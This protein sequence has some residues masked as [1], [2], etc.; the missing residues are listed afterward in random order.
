VGDDL[1]KSRSIADV[2]NMVRRDRNHPSV[3]IWEAS[4]NESGMD[5]VYMQAAHNAVHE[6]YP[7]PYTYTSGWIDAVYDIYIPARQHAKPPYYWNKYHMKKPILIS[8]YGDWEYYAQ[9]AGF[10]QKAYNDIT[11]EERNSRQL[12]SYG[13]KRLMQQALNFQ[14]AHNDNL[15]GKNL[16][17]ANWLMFD[18]NRGY[19]P[20]IESSGIADIFRLPKFAYY[21]YQSQADILAN[22]MGGFN[23][24]MVVIA[25]YYNDPSSQEIKVYSNCDEVELLLN[26]K[27]VGKQSADKAENSKNLTHAPFT[28]TLK[29]F[30][31]GTL[32][33]NAY[34]AG[35][36]MASSAQTTPS[37]AV[38]LKLVLDESGKPLTKACGD[39]VFVYASVVDKDGV[40]VPQ[41]T[42]R[43]AFTV[44][45]DATL[46]GANPF[47]A[48]AG[49]ATI[50]LK[51]GDSAGN[52]TIEASSPGLQT[53]SLRLTL[54]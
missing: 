43:V 22:Q 50:L 52:I 44:K 4:L 34:V 1:F 33:A 47:E 25:N 13:Q 54:K 35:K 26:G 31:P 18:Y 49:I 9:N 7:A 14:E 11:E 6:E 51:A 15:N 48:E 42:N 41:A 32:T 21:F 12:R 53:T 10:N 19:A 24:P 20:D 3:I 45:G 16:G 28:F 27:S 5:S 36:L 23:K 38:G 37:A 17:D 30:I 40:M 46:I 8:E 39:V 2:R 29:E